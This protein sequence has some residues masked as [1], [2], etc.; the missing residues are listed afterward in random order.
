MQNTDDQEA[1]KRHLRTTE[2]SPWVRRF[3]SLV[4]KG[5][6]A[7]GG[8]LD[9]AAGNGRHARLFLGLGHRVL[10][11]DRNAGPLADLADEPEAEVMEL[12]LETGPPA[13]DPGGALEGRAFNGIVVVNYLHRPLMAG[14]VGALAPKGV[15]IYETFARGN[16]R[17][18]RPRNPDHLLMA[19]ELL[20]LAEGRLQV[21]A[22][23]HGVA[24]TAEI[25]GV[26]QRLCAVNDLGAGD[27]D[28]GEPAPHPIPLS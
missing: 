17:F 5:D 22:Y 18:V 11:V 16:E 19:G 8:V 10:A 3:A 6:G 26:K 23:E 7:T 27:R 15:L 20:R 12:D 28:D 21:V 25:P 24:E 2:P 14:L 13:F 1:R 4:P 9:L